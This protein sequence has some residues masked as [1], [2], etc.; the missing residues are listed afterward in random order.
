MSSVGTVLKNL[1]SNGTTRAAIFLIIILILWSQFQLGGLNVKLVNSY[2]VLAL[3]L[4]VAAIGVT[5]VIIMGQFDLSAAGLVTLVDVLVATSLTDMNPW[6]MALIMVALGAAIGL[7]NGLFVVY[8]KLPAIAV[9]LATLIILGGVSL[10]L[11]DMPGG[12]V[13][14]ALID[15]VKAPLIVPRALIILIVIAILWLLFRRTRLGLYMFALGEDEEALR[16]SGV[17]IKPVKLTIFALAGALYAVAGVLLAVST[18][19]GDANIA[20][21]FLLSTFAAVAIGGT[22]FI[23]GTGSGIGTMFG[24]LVLL[25]IPKLLFVLHVSNWLAQVV[26]GAIIILAVLIGAIAVRRQLKQQYLGLRPIPPSE[27]AATTGR[28]E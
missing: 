17:A 1:L 13:P 25:A 4:V 22:A 19:T 26:T 3:P 28:V 6:L 14:K 23:G 9:T 21:S 12:T 11:L 7:V 24:A 2:M 10:V 8:G 16:L 20:N 15:F 5:L 27:L 18:E